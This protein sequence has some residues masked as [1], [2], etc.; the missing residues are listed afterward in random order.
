[1]IFIF[2]LLSS[3]GSTPLVDF[4]YPFPLPP[5]P[6]S[7]VSHLISYI[8]LHSISVYKQPPHAIPFF[9]YSEKGPPVLLC[10][11]YVESLVP[12]AVCLLYYCYLL[13]YLH[14]VVELSVPPSC[15]TQNVVAIAM[16][17]LYTRTCMHT[18][19]LD[20][21]FSNFIGLLF[22]CFFVWCEYSK[23]KAESSES[24]V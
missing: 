24:S 8:Y 7:F 5:V 12:V 4:I 17:C 2:S 15:I 22:R 3:S 23:C 10:L 14:F 20:I 1:M 18:L 19:L 16:I 11:V 6:P 9:Y 21:L 13:Y